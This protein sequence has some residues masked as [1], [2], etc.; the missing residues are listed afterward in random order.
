[1]RV[2]IASDGS[3]GAE[4][5]IGLADAIRWPPDSLL[6]VVAVAEP[7]VMLG[8]PL[9]PETI[10]MPTE[11]E[12]TLADFHQEQVAQ[13]ARKRRPDGRHVEGVVR[14]GR[15]ATVLVDEAVAVG[16]DLILIG[17]RG[18][19]Q[20]A[21]LLLGSVSREVVDHAPCP[22]LVVRTPVLRRVLLASDGSTASASAEQLLATWSIFDEVPI[23]V[24]SVAHVAAPWHTGIAPTMYRQVMADHA[25]DVEHATAEHAQ[26]AHEVVERLAAAGRAVD[27][28]T[29]VGDAAAEIVHAADEWDADLVVIGSRGMTGI[30]RM[31]LG[32]VARN[33]LDASSRSV[34]VVHPHA[35]S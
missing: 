31:V 19:G 13:A 3:P 10:V 17:S 4:L 12:A 6:R 14:H 24:V 32:S 22:V 23:R 20:I 30:S 2:V 25:L 29:P 34:L 18:H 7:I 9:I 16:A 21:R 11:L 1:M 33:V 8:G 35:P 27:A 26:T 5:A 15:P 28:V